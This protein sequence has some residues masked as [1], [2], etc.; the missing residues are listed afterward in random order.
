MRYPL[1]GLGCALMLAVAV[2]PTTHANDRAPQRKDDAR[3]DDD[4]DVDGRDKDDRDG[5]GRGPAAGAAVV[6]RLDH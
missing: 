5:K 4:R 1:L 2:P 6:E 3:Y